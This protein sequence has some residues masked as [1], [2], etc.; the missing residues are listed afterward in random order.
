MDRCWCSA[1]M[2]GVI[3]LIGSAAANSTSDATPRSED[4]DLLRGLLPRRRKSTPLRVD[5]RDDDRDRATD[6]Y[7]HEGTEG[8]HFAD[9]AA[10]DVWSNAARQ[11]AYSRF[12]DGFMKGFLWYEYDRL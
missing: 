6:F 9:Q 5:D 3:W 12:V 11:S 4:G 1:A 7:A 10:R 2:Y 8:D